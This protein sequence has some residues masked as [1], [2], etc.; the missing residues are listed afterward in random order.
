[1][2]ETIEGRKELFKDFKEF[3]ATGL[4]ELVTKGEVHPK[5]IVEA[6][7][8]RI[9]GL[10]PEL[11]AV[12]RT[13]FD[14]AL[15]E[16]E[17]IDPDPNLPLAGIP[18]LLKD[19]TQGVAGERL[20]HGSR[21]FQNYR[22]K[23]DS[24]FV[25][26]LRLAGVIF[27]GFTNVPE[28]SLMG[29]TEPKAYGPTRNPW[30]T[31]YTPG[32]SSGGSGAAVASGMV[33]IA[34]AND[35]GGSIRIPAAYCGLF[36]LKPSRGRTP[37]GPD[38]G[39]VWQGAAAEHVLTRTVRDSALVL[40]ILKGPEKGGA[41]SIPNDPESYV[42]QLEKPLPKETRIAFT[43]KSPVGGQ[44]HPEAAK[45]VVKTAEYLEELGFIVEEK[46]APVDGHVVANSYLTL[47]LGE[48]AATLRSA[49]ELI[50]RKAT[51]K[52]VEITTWFLG[53]IG[54][55]TSAG[56]FV[57]A[58]K[59][60]DHLAYQMATFHET[61]DFYMTPTT[62]QPP[63]KIG[64]QNP[65]FGQ[66]L[67]LKL[68]SSLNLGKFLKKTG[69]IEQIFMQSY[70]RTPFTQLANLTGQPAMSVPVHLTPEG[71]PLGVQFI[72]SRGEE[73]KLLRLA[74]L[75]EK[76]PLWIDNKNNPFFRK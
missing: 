40:D 8:E 27:L 58:I 37:V 73:G 9:E 62:A 2:R 13:M 38:Q 32:G 53:K 30:H 68:F 25:R 45:A 61:Y 52:D 15:K 23:Q 39:R 70:E 47:Y 22:P 76:S 41:F 49:E 16:V 44:V 26:R 14:R 35:G 36:G 51:A 33:P 67:L 5:E 71:L 24:E 17:Q 11:N 60:W 43:T 4:K 12:I 69:I 34:G 18:F 55:V 75:L 46:E 28:F 59:A 7:I 72:A 6:A 20:T 56:E 42:N 63:S 65:R 10:N 48:V 3:D 57:V 64:E 50:G 19:N 29:T 54:E 21:L 74:R 31:D 1:M 66:E